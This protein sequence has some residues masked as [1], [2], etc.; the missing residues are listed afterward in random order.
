[1]SLS[2]RCISLGELIDSFAASSLQLNTSFSSAFVASKTNSF[3]VSIIATAVLGPPRLMSRL[4]FLKNT[5]F[6]L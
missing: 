5:Y 3:V 1:M 6:K 2:S 4:F